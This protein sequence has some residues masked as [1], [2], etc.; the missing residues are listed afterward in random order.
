M[1]EGKVR[2]WTE[3]YSPFIC[4]GDVHAPISTEVYA[5]DPVGIGMG[6]GVYVVVSPV[7]G[8][9]Y[10]CETITGAIVGDSIKQVKA[11]VASADPAVLA[12]QVAHA[13]ERVKDA[14]CI[15]NEK[16][17]S[18]FRPDPAAADEAEEQTRPTS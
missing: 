9:T 2:I 1:S 4:G 17:W 18:M 13:E 16:F 11:D 15:S 14:R 10:I 7:S 8:K 5:G 3:A 6:V 12:E